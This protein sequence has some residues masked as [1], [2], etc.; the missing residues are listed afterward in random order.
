LIDQNDLSIGDHKMKSIRIQNLRS[1][2]DTGNIELRPITILLGENSSGKS[3]FLRSFPLFRQSQST[4]ITGPL[5]WFGQFVDFG[6]FDES[7]SIHAKSKHMF[8]D[9]DFGRINFNRRYFVQNLPYHDNNQIDVKTHISIIGDA[10]REAIVNLCEIEIE[11]EHKIKIQINVDGNLSHFSINGRDYLK[12]TPDMRSGHRRGLFPQ[13]FISEFVDK[14]NAFIMRKRPNFRAYAISILRDYVHHNTSDNK[15]EKLLLRLEIGSSKKMLETMKKVPGSFLASWASRTQ[16]WSINSDEFIKI[17]DML[18]LVSIPDVFVMCDEEFADFAENIR[19]IAPL[20]ATAERYY[21]RQNLAVDEVDFQGQN[22]AM[23]LKNLT[24]VEKRNFSN[25]IEDLFG[26]YPQA[27]QRGGHISLQLNQGAQSRF[28]LADMGFGYSQVLPILTQL[29]QLSQQRQQYRGYRRRKA[30]ITFAVEQPEL[31][32]HPRMQMRVAK[33][34]ANIIKEAQ[35]QKIDLRL[36]IETHSEAIVNTLGRLIAEKKL[37]SDDVNVVI[38][39]KPQ[40]D[41][42]SEVRI[43]KYDEDGFLTN[44]PYGFFEPEA[45]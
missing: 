39:E 24:D 33:A 13:L 34:F 11:E 9:F 28:N 5:L 6:S 3:T 21:R 4:S 15:L 18:I 22:L 41:K 37:S 27:I 16:G 14:S 26:F 7:I 35:K 30:P 36:V 10:K 31:H 44:W 45:E 19:Y 20:R 2:Q 40:A 1:L 25:W 29:W 8:F 38:F 17:R 12:V 43:S 23:F 32:L 42:S